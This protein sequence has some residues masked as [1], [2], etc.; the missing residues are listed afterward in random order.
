M[1][2]S[3][4]LFD[5]WYECG[6]K[7]FLNIWQAFDYQKESGYFPH[8]RFDQEFLNSIKNIKRP[9]NLNHNYI[10]N[11]IVKRLKQLRNEYK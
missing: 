11:L 9:K 7:R 3:H 6:D 10:K 1:S 4:A 2:R 8:Y 5:Q